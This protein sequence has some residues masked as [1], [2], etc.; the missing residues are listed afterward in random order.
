VLIP[1]DDLPLQQTAESLAYL[2]TSDRDAYGRYWYNG[3]APDGEFYF[4]IALA[5]YPNRDVMD[6]ALSIVRKDGSQDSFR[7]SRRCPVDR[8][9]MEVGPFKLEMTELMR[10]SRVTIAENDTGIAADLTFTG[11]TPVH[12]EP[13]D[14]IRPHVR[15]MM[16]MK[17]YTQF[18]RW[19][20][21]I[22][23]KGNRQ[24]VVNAYGIRDRSWGWRMN[25]EPTGGAPMG[26]RLQALY[27]W[28]PLIWEDRCTHYSVWETGDG[29]RL[30]DFAQI[31]PLYD[32]NA[33]FDPLDPEGFHELAAGAHR[34]QF[35]D[36]GSRFATGG[37]ID[38]I[39]GEETVTVTLEPLLRFHMYGIGYQHPTWGHGMWKDELAWTSEHWNINDIDKLIPHF[40]HAQ[41]VVR[42]TD[43]NRVGY[44]VLEQAIGASPH[45]TLPDLHVENHS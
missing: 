27:L 30:K 17:R 9:Q 12:E 14:M 15:L 28:A 19:N 8:T 11:T 3:F 1:H 23:I 44:G 42:V 26:K 20:G 45:Y 35:G 40:Q 10:I 43:G 39:D 24:E 29:T 31:F 36:P 18:G 7:A 4:G 37:Q 2:D 21:Y 5:V 6:C 16:K 41:Q 33:A 32:A 34:L 25:G 13:T 22:D 38:L